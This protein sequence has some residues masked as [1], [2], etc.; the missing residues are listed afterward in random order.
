MTGPVKKSGTPD[1]KSGKMGGKTWFGPENRTECP[2]K[3]M[4]L[5]KGRLYIS[6]CTVP[7]MVL[8]K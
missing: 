4:N 7:F 5:W 2:E 1:Q 8:H 3:K 6:L